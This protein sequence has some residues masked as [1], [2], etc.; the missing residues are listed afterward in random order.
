VSGPAVRDETRVHGGQVVEDSPKSSTPLRFRDCFWQTAAMTSRPRPVVYVA[1]AYAISASLVV[2]GSIPRCV[3]HAA[4]IASDY[5]RTLLFGFLQHV[6]NR[7]VPIVPKGT[8]QSRE[9]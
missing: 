6:Q 9:V 2:K 7:R 8:Q 4:P 5:N 1:H 3:G